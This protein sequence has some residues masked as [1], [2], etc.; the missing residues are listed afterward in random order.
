MLSEVNSEMKKRNYFVWKCVCNDKSMRP[1]GRKIQ[2]G[3]GKWN[4]VSSKYSLKDLTVLKRK[5]GKP[6]EIMP[7]CSRCGRKK[8]LTMYMT[9]VY[10]FDDRDEA[11]FQ[12][13][14]LNIENGVKY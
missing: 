1:I 9:Q 7:A 12:E 14:R 3:C 5:D 11:L 13:R 10:R 2:K 6:V 8:R 4:T